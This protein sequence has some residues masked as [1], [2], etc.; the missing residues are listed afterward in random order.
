MPFSIDLQKT[1]YDPDLYFGPRSITNRLNYAFHNANLDIQVLKTLAVS[2][3]FSS[4]KAKQRT[5]VYKFAVLNREKLRSTTS[6]RY[7]SL[8]QDQTRT[9]VKYLSIFE[10]NFIT[11]IHANFDYDK[12]KEFLMMLKGRHDFGSFASNKARLQTFI[13]IG[14]VE[15][16]AEF[17]IRDIIHIDLKQMAAPPFSPVT[18]QSDCDIFDYYEMTITSPSFYRNQVNLNS[19]LSHG[20]GMLVDKV[21]TVESD[22][23]RMFGK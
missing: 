13:N 4:R 17:F 1:T 3:N 8:F 12:A 22:D 20:I 18:I 23:S 19:I 9:S 21:C 7:H 11:E 14:T 16:P 6:E 5:Y 10:R 15:M 2:S